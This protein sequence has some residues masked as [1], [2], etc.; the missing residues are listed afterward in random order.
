MRVWTTR[1]EEV[2]TIKMDFNNLLEYLK[3]EG[4]LDYKQVEKK[5]NKCNKACIKVRQKGK[6]TNPRLDKHFAM[7]ELALDILNILNLKDTSSISENMRNNDF[8]NNIID[9]RVRM[10]Q[11]RNAEVE[12]TGEG[13]KSFYYSNLDKKP[14]FKS[15][16]KEQ[17]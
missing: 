17:N 4:T 6:F 1:Q 7:L 3:K 5:L 9:Y 15:Y 12:R 13:Y 2:S 14:K 8:I 11:A 16:D 10:E